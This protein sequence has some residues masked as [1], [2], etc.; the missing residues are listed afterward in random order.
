MKTYVTVQGDMW[1][2]IAFQQMGNEKYV[3]DLLS[4]NPEHL[5]T[6]I[7]PAGVTLQIP[8]VSEDEPSSLP[9]WRR[10]A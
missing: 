6:F 1:D 7:F 4:A 8:D 10:K 3:T 5:Q 9:P 2:S